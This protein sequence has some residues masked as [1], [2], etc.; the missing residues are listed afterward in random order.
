M[1]YSGHGTAR[2]HGLTQ[3]Y[4]ITKLTDC[5]MVLPLPR[6]NQLTNFSLDQV[7]LQGADVADV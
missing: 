2:R 1:G 6:L 3:I 5:Q 7:A 4:S